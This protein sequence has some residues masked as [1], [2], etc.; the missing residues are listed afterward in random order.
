M[1]PRIV[2]DTSVLTAA[3]LR[4]KEGASSNVLRLCL[5]GRC[6]PVLGAKLFCEYESVL[7][8][9]EL[10]KNCPLDAAERL[11]FLAGLAAVCEWATVHYLWRPNLPDEGDNHLIELAM[12]GDARII[13]TH[14]VRDFRRAELRFPDI[15]ILTPAGFLQTVSII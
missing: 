15:A 2:V 6:Q 9:T 5:Q 12:A 4:N 13:V 10:F 7:A 8:R 1:S 11:E 3:L 14:N